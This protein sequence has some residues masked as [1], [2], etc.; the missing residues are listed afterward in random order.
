[1]S[2]STIALPIGFLDRARIVARP[3]FN[4]WLVPPCALAIHLCIG[5][6]YGFSVFWLPLSKAIGIT[7]SVACP[8][9]ASIFYYLTT[10]TC[11]WKVPQLQAWMFGLFFVF[12]GSAAAIWGGWLERRSGRA[13]VVAKKAGRGFLHSAAVFTRTSCGSFGFLGSASSAAAGL[14]YISARPS[15]WFPDRRGMAT[16]L[17]SWVSAVP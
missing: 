11:D 1:M 17:V 3:G 4:R 15:S 10:T 6:A 5:M 8:A 7:K 2:A 14:G 12:L 13:G 9:D 16:G